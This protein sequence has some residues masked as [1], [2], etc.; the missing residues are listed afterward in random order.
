MGPLD[1]A[2]LRSPSLR[3]AAAASL[4]ACGAALVAAACGDTLVHVV[5]AGG[6][7]GGA[8]AGSC[9]GGGPPITLPG[10]N[11]CTADLGRQLFRLALCSCTTGTVSGELVTDA[12]SSGGAS[13]AEVAA[14][15]GANESWALN[16]RV[17]VGGSID[18]GGAG[19]PPALRLRGDGTIA[20]D[21]RA[22][23][24]IDSGGVYQIGGDLFANGDI[25]IAS[26]SLAAV[27]RVHLAPGRN[28]GGV[29]AGG[30]LITEAISVPPPCDC[31]A[32]PDITSLVTGFAGTNDNEAAGVTP[33]ALARPSGPLTLPCGRYFFDEIAGDVSLSLSGRTAIFVSGSATIDGS[34]R[35]EL[36][37]EGELDLFIAGGVT[38]TGAS[39]LLGSTLAPA[40]VRVYVGGAFGLVGNVGIGAN[41]YA[42]NTEFASSVNVEMYGALHAQRLTFSGDL[43]LHYDLSILD[44]EGCQAPPLARA[45]ERSVPAGLP[46]WAPP[47]RPPELVER[48]RTLVGRQRKPVGPVFW[49]PRPSLKP[50]CHKRC[51]KGAP[52]PACSAAENGCR[53]K[54]IA[55]SP[56]RQASGFV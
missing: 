47:T 50:S 18:A 19:T 9:E 20:G 15:L 22:G 40:R 21:V 51:A 42:P 55:Y 33:R 41:V 46:F 7:G 23:G 54:G 49:L 24:G 12:L 30:G 8:P 48:V 32:L 28:A 16:S 52:R 38:L 11:R 14:S 17:S 35:V 45:Q 3:R 13:D 37:P 25:T 39:S 4:L 1:T 44:A 27:G 29:V 53:P 43:T 2:A 10:S 31:G 34:L 5:E 6:S 26:G 36:G 56:S